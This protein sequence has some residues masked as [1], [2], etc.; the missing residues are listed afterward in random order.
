MELLLICCTVILTPAVS[1]ATWHGARAMVDA[2]ANLQYQ[3]LQ[4]TRES[5]WREKAE[6][7]EKIA[8]DRMDALMQ[9]TQEVAALRRDVSSLETRLNLGGKR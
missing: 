6:R 3:R 9:H 2:Y 5:I 7:F 1:I 4:E 8:G